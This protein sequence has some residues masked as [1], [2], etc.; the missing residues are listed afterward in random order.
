MKTPAWLQSALFR[1]Y[2][3]RFLWLW[4]VGK[5]AIVAGAMFAR[6]PPWVF[7]PAPEAVACAV[8]LLVL[9]AFIRVTGEDVLLGNL[10]QGATRAVLDFKTRP[11]EE[12]YHAWP[13]AH[14]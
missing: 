14:T 10:E 6:D 9:A 13:G 2:A 7:R 5:G 1:A 4:V 12:W 11:L 8:E 3:K